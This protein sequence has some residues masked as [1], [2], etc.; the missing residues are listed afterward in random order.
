[1]GKIRKINP[2]SYWLVG[3]H[4]S[5]LAQLAS[6]GYFLTS[7]NQLFSTFEK[8][9]PANMNYRIELVN[10]KPLSSEQVE[11]YEQSGWDYVT[12]SKLYHVFASPV[13]RG[14]MEIYTDPTEQANTV[15][16]LKK[17]SKRNGLIVTITS[18][19]MLLLVGGGMIVNEPFFYWLVQGST[20]LSVLLV[21]FYAVQ[22]I[23]MFRAYDGLKQLAQQLEQG[24][25]IDH[26][27]PWQR[28]FMKDR[29][30]SMLI[31][32]FGLFMIAAPFYSIYKMD[33]QTLPADT[34]S[35]PILR[36]EALLDGQYVRSEVAET[37]DDVDYS[38][39]WDQQW[40][41]LAPTIYETTQQ[42]VHQAN[43]Q[44][45]SLDV[46]YYDMRTKWL[47][48]TMLQSV[49]EYKTFFRDDQP[50]TYAEHDRFD[51][52]Y[53]YE[54]EI[55]ETFVYARLGK[56][57]IDIRYQGELP[58]EQIIDEAAMLYAKFE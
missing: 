11:L 33:V 37:Y 30:W 42:G 48:K 9:P 12:S 10:G 56:Q 39:S 22:S 54:S 3:E 52:L 29:V 31:L 23:T 49:I 17:Q 40:N 53:V 43:Q 16:Y 45:E 38:H 27:A 15:S 34:S 4:E 28:E 24:K 57:V 47:A 2:R 26:K 8:R 20:T 58:T 36:L 7:M 51:E 32:L 18:T 44:S 35:K 14:A 13:E 19:L 46:D 25:P 5:W 6:N 21:C 55:G 50:V 1:M 41:I